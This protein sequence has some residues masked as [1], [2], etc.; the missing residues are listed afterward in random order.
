MAKKNDKARHRRACKKLLKQAN[1]AYAALRN[2]PK[3]WS[4]E[5]EERTLWEATLFDGLEEL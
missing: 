5:L 4:E 2:D 1:K 3:A